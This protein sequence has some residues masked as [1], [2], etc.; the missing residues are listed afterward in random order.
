MYSTSFVL[1]SVKNCFFRMIFIHICF[2]TLFFSS[3]PKSRKFRWCCHTVCGKRPM[4]FRKKQPTFVT[5]ADMTVFITNFP[6]CI[7]QHTHTHRPLCNQQ[8]IPCAVTPPQCHSSIM[9]P[10]CHQ[11]VVAP[12]CHSAIYRP[13]QGD[14]TVSQD[15]WHQR[16]KCGFHPCYRTTAFIAATCFSQNLNL[17]FLSH[18]AVGGHTVF[19]NN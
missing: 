7:R 6:C 3:K 4:L 12:K 1:I 17:L 16:A 18:Y 8:H 14:S 19:K 15:R 10:R 13:W 5:S 11:P 2:L 9:T